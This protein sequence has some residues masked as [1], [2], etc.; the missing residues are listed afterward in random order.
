VT[1]KKCGTYVCAHRTDSASVNQIGPNYHRNS[2]Y[3]NYNQ[4]QNNF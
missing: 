4:A 1:G 2:D 3:A